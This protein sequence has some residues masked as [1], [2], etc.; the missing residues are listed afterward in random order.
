VRREHG[1]AHP[2]ERVPERQRLVGIGHV[3][4]AAQPAAAHLARERAKVDDPAAR[5]LTTVAPVAQPARVLRG[6]EGR[7]SRR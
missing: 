2:P 4:R 7:A 1:T 5:T 3:E 6:R